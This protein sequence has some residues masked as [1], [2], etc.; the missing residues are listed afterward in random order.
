MADIDV[1]PVPIDKLTTFTEGALKSRHQR[2]VEL[3]SKYEQRVVTLKTDLAEA[4][5]VLRFIQQE[6]A[7][8]ALAQQLACGDV[9]RVKCPACQG[10]GMKPSD[11]T[12]GRVRQGSAFENTGGGAALNSTP[13]ID[14][15]N[16]CP[17][18]KGQRWQIMERFKG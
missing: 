6:L 5:R 17:D 8:A 4:E 14:E 3:N 12:G 7:N 16:R 9:V 10:T 1:R 18:C 2:L 15:R 13:V 11:V